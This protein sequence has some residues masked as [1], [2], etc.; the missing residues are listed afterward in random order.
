MWASGGYAQE[1]IGR[2]GVDFD[3]E[4]GALAA[5]GAASEAVLAMIL[6]AIQAS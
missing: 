2:H 6:V 5:D 3:L 1:Q 4:G